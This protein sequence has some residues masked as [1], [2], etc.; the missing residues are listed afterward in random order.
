MPALERSFNIPNLIILFKTEAVP[1]PQTQ[2]ELTRL[3]QETEKPES[4]GRTRTATAWFWG[5]HVGN[6]INCSYGQLNF[7]FVRH[8]DFRQI[9]LM[10]ALSDF[11]PTWRP[12][13]RASALL[14]HGPL[15]DFW[16]YLNQA[17]MSVSRDILI[18]PP[19]SPT[20]TLTAN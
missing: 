2:T 10:L 5:E 3:P 20:H 4:T 17:F 11:F 9:I 13:G 16:S 8:G 7:K 14:Q 19:P 12:L 6:W 1:D 15:T 18:L